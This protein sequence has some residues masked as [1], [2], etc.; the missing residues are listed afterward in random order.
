M[1]GSISGKHREI[2]RPRIELQGNTAFLKEFSRF[3][4][5]RYLKVSGVFFLNFVIWQPSIG[6]FSQVL[7]QD[8]RK[9]KSFVESCYFLTTCRTTK[10]KC[11]ELSFFSFSLFFSTF[12]AK[13]LKIFP[14]RTL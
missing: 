2:P 8:N 14:K 6:G 9:A 1:Q 4:N 12:L 10:S 3:E 13:I 5:Q 11:G 7:L